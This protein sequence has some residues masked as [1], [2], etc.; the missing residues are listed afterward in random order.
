DMKAM[1]VLEDVVEDSVEGSVRKNLVDA[2]PPDV[3]NPLRNG[4]I[5]I[6]ALILMPCHPMTP[7]MKMIGGHQVTGQVQWE[8]PSPA[9]EDVVEDLTAWREWA[10]VG[11]VVERFVAHMAAWVVGDS[12]LRIR[13]ERKMCPTRRVEDP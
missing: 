7:S 2:Y 8:I 10:A 12:I 11:D 9:V 13:L 6:R 4:V 1:E 3:L 5:A